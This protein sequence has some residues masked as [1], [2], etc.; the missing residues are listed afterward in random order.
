MSFADLP[1]KNEKSSGRGMTSVKQHLVAVGF[2]FSVLALFNGCSSSP[3]KIPPVTDAVKLQIPDREWDPQRPDKSVGW[4]GEAC[5]Q[6]AMD[7]YGRQV[8][9]ETINESGQ[10]RHPDLYA[11]DI[12]KAL[13]N[14]GVSFTADE[15]PPD[16]SDFIAWIQHQLREQHPVICGCK[17]YP[18][19]HPHWNLDHFVLAVGFNS[20]GLWLNTQLDLSGQVLVPYSQLCSRRSGYSFA[21]RG[22]YYFGRAIVG[23]AS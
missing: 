20:K 5:I 7:Y 14:L 21:N 18:D 22:N 19:E 11:G 10:P 13:N 17:I 1:D 16:V 15:S 2:G 9:Q 8:T 12:D 3:A 6:M 4:C 23:V